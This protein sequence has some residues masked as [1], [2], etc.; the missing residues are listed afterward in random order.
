MPKYASRLYRRYMRDIPR[1]LESVSKKEEVF[2]LPGLFLNIGTQRR[3]VEDAS[4]LFPSPEEARAKGIHLYKALAEKSDPARRECLPV[5]TNLARIINEGKTHLEEAA[6]F[7]ATLEDPW[8]E[9]W[10]QASIEAARA[11]FENAKLLAETINARY[12]KVKLA[13][14]L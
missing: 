4:F 11:S 10:S 6:F 7:A 8:A 1:A 14:A 9:K 13:P 5:F 3:D 12:G 2:T